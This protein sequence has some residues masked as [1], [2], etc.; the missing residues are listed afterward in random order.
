MKVMDT[1]IVEIKKTV[2]L[3]LSF[4]FPQKQIA[5]SSAYCTRFPCTSDDPMSVT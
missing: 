5:V 2:V 3:E 1:I 4:A